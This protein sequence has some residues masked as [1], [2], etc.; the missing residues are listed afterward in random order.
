MDEDDLMWL[1]N[2]ENGHVLANQFDG[3]F[4]SSNLAFRKIKSVFRDVK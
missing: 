1:K 3:N 2:K 4:R